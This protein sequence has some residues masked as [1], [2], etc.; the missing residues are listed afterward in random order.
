MS[1]NKM[2]LVQKHKEMLAQP[3]KNSEKE[4]GKVDLR[5]RE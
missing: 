3:S 5:T 4:E 2:N 1:V